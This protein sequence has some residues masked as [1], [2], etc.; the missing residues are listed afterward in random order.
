MMGSPGDTPTFELPALEAGSCPQP[1]SQ[2]PRRDQFPCYKGSRSKASAVRILPA[3]RHLQGQAKTAL[4]S[5]PPFPQGWE[6]PTKGRVPCPP[7]SQ[8][9]PGLPQTQPGPQLVSVPSSPS[10]TCCHFWLP[11][12]W[13]EGPSKTQ[14]CPQCLPLVC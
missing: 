11:A 12:V 13:A 1:P 14:R 6:T 8:P 2:V 9:I 4:H 10:A 3:A 7:P 5:Q